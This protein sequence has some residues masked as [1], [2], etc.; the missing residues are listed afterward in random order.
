MLTD[1][2]EA[3]IDPEGLYYGKTFEIIKGKADKLMSEK[4]AAIDSTGGFS[5]PQGLPFDPILAEFVRGS[6][7]VCSNWDREKDTDRALVIR[8]LGGG[9]RK[10]LHHCWK[11]GRD[12]Y[13]IDTG[14][15]GNIKIFSHPSFFKAAISSA[16]FGKP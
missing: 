6:G 11:T 15:I 13:A 1:V 4:I 5:N 3:T 9:S 8:G 7:G 10:A 14:Y 2:I 12:Y 16:I